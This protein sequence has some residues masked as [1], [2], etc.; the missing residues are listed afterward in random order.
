MTEAN[1]KRARLRPAVH[2][3][4]LKRYL[5][6]YALQKF[7]H[8]TSCIHERSILNFSEST[9]SQRHSIRACTPFSRRCRQCAQSNPPTK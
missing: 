7:A 9:A 8:M 4:Y 6:T 3:R 5:N 1:N 2:S